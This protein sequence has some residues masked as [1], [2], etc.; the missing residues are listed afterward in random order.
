MRCE[1][2][3]D[4]IGRRWIERLGEEYVPKVV[5]NWSELLIDL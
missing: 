5:W 1:R 4:G 2:G 3:G